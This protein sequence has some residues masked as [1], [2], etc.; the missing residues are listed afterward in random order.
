MK[1]SPKC[2][3]KVKKN[4]LCIIVQVKM[5]NRIYVQSA[6]FW[7]VTPFNSEMPQRI[8][9]IYRPHFLDARVRQET[10]RIWRFCI[11]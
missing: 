9:D 8:G 4:L 5:I 3:N 7:V 11:V 10:S 2:Q 1:H 6:V